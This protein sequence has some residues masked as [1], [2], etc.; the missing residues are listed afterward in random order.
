MVM[1][2]KE[3]IFFA[4][5]GTTFAILAIGFGGGLLMA[6]STL[7]ETRPQ[8]VEQLPTVRVVH[9]TSAQPPLPVTAAA[10]T[11]PL[12]RTVAPEVQAKPQAMPAED[13]VRTQ[14]TETATKQIEQDRRKAE[15]AEIKRRKQLAERKARRE[16]ARVKQRQ[17]FQQ[18]ETPHR[19]PGI[20]AFGMDEERPRS[21]GFFGN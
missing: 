1:A 2:A 7:H 15:A 16:M 14:P 10:A 11:E 19:E 20:L 6:S 9:P 4:G 13:E 18:R 8:R 12:S 17:E 5:V 21:S 3:R